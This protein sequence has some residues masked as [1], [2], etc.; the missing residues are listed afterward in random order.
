VGGDGG[1]SASRKRG[2]RH[3]SHTGG[4]A[5]RGRADGVSTSGRIAHRTRRDGTRQ[6]YPHKLPAL[7]GDPQPP[8]PGIS[9]LWLKVAFELSR[10]TTVICPRCCGTNPNVITGSLLREMSESR[11]KTLPPS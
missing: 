8:A 4:P 9:K 11:W 2:G 7:A 5:D 1:G 6:E 10:A 3:P